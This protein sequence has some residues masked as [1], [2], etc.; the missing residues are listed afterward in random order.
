MEF[1]NSFA[2]FSTLI[3]CFVLVSVFSAFYSISICR[4][5][6]RRSSGKKEKG[7]ETEL[8]G[9]GGGAVSDIKDMLV[10]NQICNN[11]KRHAPTHTN[12][13]THTHIDTKAE[14]SF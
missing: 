5:P 3:S 2:Y 8:N 4:N 9:G 13:H 14:Q 1:P 7:G 11:D 12:T 6:S 10:S